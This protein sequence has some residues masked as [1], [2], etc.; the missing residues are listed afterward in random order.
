VLRIDE[1]ALSR[2]RAQNLAANRADARGL[3]PSI[4]SFAQALDRQRRALE[5][6]PLIALSAEDA[7]AT[8]HALDEAEALALALVAGDPARDLARFAA[9]AKAS[10]IPLLR[11]DLLLEEFQIHESR[12]AGADAVLLHA[13]VLP[14]ES[15]ARLCGAA[16]ATHMDACVVCGSPEEIDRAVAARAPAVALSGDAAALAAHAP[17]RLVLLAIDGDPSLLQGKVDA[18]F[19]PE[20][21]Q[22]A[23]PAAAF[24]AAIASLPSLDDEA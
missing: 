10:T 22:S 3:V 1:A 8:A 5:R 6:V 20:I 19:D 15:L 11:A 13:A 9:I 24:R 12:A 18:L 21:A 23:D 7:G 14:G 16:R 17:R 2:R 4:R